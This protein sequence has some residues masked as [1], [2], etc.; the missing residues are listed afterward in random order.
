MKHL[1][2]KM[3]PFFLHSP[4]YVALLS[5]IPQCMFFT[6]SQGWSIRNK[7]RRVWSVILGYN[8]RS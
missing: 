2:M 6:Y 5:N 3:S 1:I 7:R 8:V 4:P